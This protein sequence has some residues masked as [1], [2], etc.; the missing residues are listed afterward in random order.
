MTGVGGPGA[1]T[2]GAHDY[3]W[4]GDAASTEIS[5]NHGVCKDCHGMNSATDAAAT[6]NVTTMWG[7]AGNHG[8][9]SIDLNGPSAQVNDANNAT[10]V[11][12]EYNGDDDATLEASDYS[13]TKA[14]HQGA[15]NA[16][17]TM[18]DSGWALKYGDFGAGTC[19]SCHGYPPLTAADLAA[20]GANYPD[21]KV[22][23][24]YGGYA[25]GGDAHNAPD[26]LATTVTA[27]A[28]WT[29]C[30]PCHPSTSHLTT[31]SVLRAN[32]SVAFPGTTYNAKSGAASFTAGGGPAAASCANVSCHGGQTTPFWEGGSISVATQCTA[33][34]AAEA[35]ANQAAASQWNSAFS[36]LHAR[37]GSVSLENHTAADGS[38]GDLQDSSACTQCHALPALHFSGM[39]TTA[40]D[41][42][43]DA[44][45]VSTYDGTGGNISAATGCKVT[46]HSDTNAGTPRWARR[47][48]T[49]VTATDGTECA[50]CH[51]SWVDG[52]VAGVSHRTDAGPSNLHGSTVTYPRRGCNECHAI[53]EAAY[54]FTPKWN[55]GAAGHHGNESIELN[56][57]SS[58]NPQRLSGADAGKTGCNG[59][60]SANDGTA[61]G[62]HSFASVTR[63]GFATLANGQ[64]S[65][66][67]VCHGTDGANFYPDSGAQ[68]GSGYENRGGAHQK[69]VAAI[70][71]NNGGTSVA[72]PAR[73]TGATPAARTPATSPPRRPTSWTA[74]TTKFKT[75]T[76]GTDA[77][78][79]FVP[80]SSTCTNV[81]C[82]SGATTPGWYY[83]PDTA[84][85]VWSP[86]SG[87][88]ATNPNQGGVLNVTWNAATDAYPSNPVSYDLYK[89]TTNSAA[90]VF[91][92]PPIATDLAGTSTT[93]TGLDVG[94][95]YYFGVRAKDNWV[96]RNVT[97]NTD[98]SAGVAPG[99]ATPPTPTQRVY[100]LTKPASATNLW[101]G[102]NT[103]LS[104]T[105]G[106]RHLRPRGQCRTP[107]ERGADARSTRRRAGV[108]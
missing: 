95:T 12:A 63:W 87:I 77:D 104:L 6:Y 83:A 51:G 48:S 59:C 22:D 33:C 13:C 44:D 90:A 45:F 81:D 39:D 47:W 60:H 37:A 41:A 35:V 75:I 101:S 88:A 5:P 79:A 52:W 94:T 27:A 70:A 25:G 69:H 74:P 32:I 92:G 11:G 34:H 62:Q 85:P 4:N 71:A 103:N 21:A 8:N 40:T 42:L 78:G 7:G 56:T 28:G 73:A 29:P 38:V 76:G 43:T 2:A 1:V 54:V 58:A 61:A 67:A 9:G 65:G 80:A 68:N 82:H 64:Y 72:T 93:V 36:G 102:V 98:I 108:S 57:A 107:V 15:G 53:G 3:D 10:P 106:T 91:A 66:C 30:L 89:S 16:N 24:A 31:T 99:A 18:G 23:T 26:H 100:Y 46:C 84:A 14:C 19:N 86:N 50:N 105:C 55:N 96:T 17:H 97:A 20:R 49:T